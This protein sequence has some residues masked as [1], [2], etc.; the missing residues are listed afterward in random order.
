MSFCAFPSVRRPPQ[1]RPTLAIN[2]NDLVEI[3]KHTDKMISS[4]QQTNHATTP[5][6]TTDIIASEYMY[7]SSTTPMESE[8]LSVNSSRDS[9]LSNDDLHSLGFRSQDD[10][11]TPPSSIAS[12]P[13]T[14]KHPLNSFGESDLSSRITS[15]SRKEQPNTWKSSKSGRQE[16]Q[17]QE[18]SFEKA[19]GSVSR[20]KH[21]T[22]ESSA[23]LSKSLPPLPPQ[24]NSR[25]LLQSNNSRESVAQK[26]AATGS[27]V[28]KDAPGSMGAKRPNEARRAAS[29]DEGRQGTLTTLPSLKVESSRKA[30]PTVPPKSVRPSKPKLPQDDKIKLPSRT[31]SPHSDVLFS[32]QDLQSSEQVINARIVLPVAH[33]KQP[34]RSHT[35]KKPS[36]GLNALTV[37]TSNPS[38]GL[39]ALTAM[40]SK[41]II[42]ENPFVN[43]SSDAGG[44]AGR[45]VPV[46]KAKPPLVAPAR[47]AIDETETGLPNVFK[48]QRKD[49]RPTPAAP[50]T[51]I[52]RACYQSHRHMNNSK[53]DI[54]QVPCMACQVDDKEIRWKCS[55]C[56]L[57][58]C[59]RCME[60]LEGI[61]DRDL[62]ALLQAR[63]KTGHANQ[64]W[65]S[66][67]WEG[68]PDGPSF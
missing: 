42:C 6:H 20:H 24:L 15:K 68:I 63:Q 44:R 32:I 43:K 23:K 16:T 34:M 57:R 67:V 29:A 1:R 4:L 7:P 45:L 33:V 25:N 2:L 48:T 31:S 12:S 60:V 55:W 19:I 51:F 64:P 21:T 27:K 9:F 18:T 10:P 8:H 58:I 49:K 35:L 53:N 30:L 36:T 62:G 39:N 65:H 37:M 38:T 22:S 59:N 28:S 26:I 54:A 11:D 47:A 40:T 66:T 52:H 3:E 50:L 13:S 56:C 41:P 17:P 14:R 46:E 5:L 61:K